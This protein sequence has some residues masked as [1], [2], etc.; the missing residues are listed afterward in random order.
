MPEQFVPPQ[1]TREQRQ[2]LRDQALV[3]AEAN[4]ENAR[5]N[6]LLARAALVALQ[7]DDGAGLNGTEPPAPAE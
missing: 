7:Q 6:L 2:S 1:L 4:V 3:Q 5:L